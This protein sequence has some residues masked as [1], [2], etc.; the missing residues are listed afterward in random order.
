M[1]FIRISIFCYEVKCN[2]VLGK[3][4][5][6]FLLFLFVSVIVVGGYYFLYVISI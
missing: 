2:K 5:V 1:F 3:N 4:F 6:V